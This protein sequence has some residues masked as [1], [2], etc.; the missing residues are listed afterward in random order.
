MCEN[1]SKNIKEEGEG[2][3]CSYAN[4]IKHSKQFRR[5]QNINRVGRRLHGI[6]PIC[7]EYPYIVQFIAMPGL[8]NII[9]KEKT[10]AI[11]SC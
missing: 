7:L 10:R 3:T 1:T 2:P 11:I 4:Q 6:E 9:S 8:K 5:C